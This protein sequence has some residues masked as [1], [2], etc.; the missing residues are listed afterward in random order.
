MSNMNH[1]RE[2]KPTADILM[3][4]MRAMGYSFESAVAD[5]V[6]NSISADAKKVSLRFAIDPSKLYVAICDDGY[7][8]NAEELFDAMKYGSEQK[9]AGRTESDLGRFGL[10]LKAASLSQCRKLT[11]ASKKNGIVSAFVWDLDVIEEKKDWYIVECEEEGDLT[12]N[13]QESIESPDGLRI[14]QIAGQMAGEEV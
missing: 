11:V 5:I 3:L 13:G 4:S 2:N 9:R 12:E 14:T 7:G 8:M 6:D 1:L 10:G